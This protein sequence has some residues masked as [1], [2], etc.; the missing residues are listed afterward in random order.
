ME[1]SGF[2]ITGRSGLR[3]F[4]SLEI[5][6]GKG[7]LT[8]MLRYA[9]LSQFIDNYPADTSE[10]IVDFADL[11]SIHAALEDLYGGR[12]GKVLMTHVGR[13]MWNELVGPLADPNLNAPITA[14]KNLPQDQRI[15][16]IINLLKNVYEATGDRHI[17][18]EET[19]DAYLFKTNP[20]PCCWGRKM[21]QP[22][23]N[24]T[25]GHL[26]NAVSWATDQLH[27][28]LQTTCRGCG[29]EVCTFK[30][31]KVVEKPSA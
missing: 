10:R 23:C 26:Q 4:E 15:G 1:K 22:G 18:V 9:K 7:G 28:I 11:S 30:I 8:A 25:A 17:D 2:H 14:V 3:V 16:S 6:L 24:V 20:C 12:G 21:A 19:E 31:L 27:P 5:V 29:D 13:E